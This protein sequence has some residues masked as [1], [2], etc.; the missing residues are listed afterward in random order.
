MANTAINGDTDY[1]LDWRFPYA[2]FKSISGLTDYLLSGFSSGSSSSGNNISKSGADIVGGS[3][4]YTAFSDVVTPIGTTPTT[5]TI[6]FVDDLAG[7]GD[8]TQIFAGDTIY[9]RV[10]DG[11]INNNNAT[12]Q[13]VTVT[14]MPPVEHCCDYT[15][16][17]WRQQ[18]HI[19][20]LHSHPGP[21]PVAN[22]GILQT[23][24]GGDM[25]TAIY[26][27]GIDASYNM[28]LIRSDSL[29]VISLIPNIKPR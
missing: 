24:P 2:T 26:V 9:I 13:T 14:S 7:N 3:D 8:V 10:D 16:G 21:R 27:D 6:K 23:T 4:L 29:Y 28:N 12:L 20:R 22:D 18:R 25:V 11:D 15:D 19:Y 1:F 17:N 5:G